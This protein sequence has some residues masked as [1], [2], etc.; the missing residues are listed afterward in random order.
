MYSEV[1]SPSLS[2][3]LYIAEWDQTTS[4]CNVVPIPNATP[5]AG[6]QDV[7][8]P[9]YSLHSGKIGEQERDVTQRYQAH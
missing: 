2:F 7:V 6:G 3:L 1:G 4:E 5:E 9:L 8:Q